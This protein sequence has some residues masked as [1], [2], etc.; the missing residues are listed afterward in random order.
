MLLNTELETVDMYMATGGAHSVISGRIAYV[1]GLTGPAI[2]VD[3]A[4]SSSLVAT[5]YAIKSLRTGECRMALAGGVNAIL[6][7]DVTI[8]LSKARMMATEGRCKAFAADAD[9]FVRSEGCG[10]LVLKRLAD[11][12]ADGDPILAV[13]R[14]TAIN[15]DGRSN[16]LTA[17]NGPSQVAVIRAA[18]ADAGLS[19]ADV[20]YVE[21]HGTG[22]TLG[23]P[24]E[25]Q[26]LG[27]AFA[28]GR[29]KD[30]PLMIGSIKTNMGHLE[31]AA[32]VAG[33][34]KLILSLQHAEIPPH[35]HLK[36]RSPHIPWEDLPLTIPTARTAWTGRRIGATSSFGFSGTNVHMIV[37]AYTPTPA[38]AP[39]TAQSRGLHLLTL[40]AKTKPALQSLVE[41][42]QHF[43]EHQ[44]D[45]AFS[46]IAYAANTSRAHLPQRLAL[47]AASAQQARQKLAE[48]QADPSA[49][50]VITSDQPAARPPDVAFLYTGHGAQ[51]AGMGRKLYDSEPV[52]RRVIDRCSEL[53]AAYLPKPLIEALYPGSDENATL[54]D[55]MT[56]GQP[57]IFA[58]QVA[59]AELWRDWGIQPAV[60]TGHSL[61][62]YAAAVAAG[63]FSLED[64]LKLVCARGRLMDNL[65]QSGS[66]ASVF[67]TEEEISAVIQPLAG[68]VSIAVIN[69]PTNIVISGTPS[70]V[71]QA[72]AAFEAKGI[73][74]RRLAIA[75]GAHSP[76]VDPMRDEF[77]RVAASVTFSAPRIDLV[78]CTTG[79]PVTAAEVSSVEYWWRHLRQ[80]VQFA[81]VMQTLQERGQAV[82]VEIGPHPVLLSI[83]QR[84]LPGGYGVWIPSLREKTD[85]TQ[86][87][88]EALGTL[89]TRGANIHWA[90]VY[91]GS[92]RS[93]LLL[94]T[95]P[96]DH[97]RYWFT[98][99]AKP[100]HS[101]AAAG[102]GLSPLLGAR[103]HSPALEDAVYQT[104]ISAVWPAY[105]DHHRIFGT[106]IAPSPAFIEMAARA[107]Q[108]LFGSG[109]YRVSNLAI[110]EAMILPEEGLR[111]A[112]IILTPNGENSA[113]FKIVSLEPGG[114][115][116]THTTGEVARQDAPAPD[117][118]PANLRLIADAQARC[119]E[120]MRGDVYYDNV[121]ALGLEFGESFRG[122]QHVWRRDGEALGK[123][124]LPE[125]LA[126]DMKNY[127][128]HPA[129]LDACFHLLGAPLPGAKVD[130][131][132]LL[133]GIEHFRMYRP[134]SGTLWNHT[135]L[136]DH[137]GETFSGDIRLYDESG[138]LVAE[139]Q[140]L[141][142]KRANRDLLMRAVRPRFD[143]WL[144]AVDW[145]PRPLP[146]EQTGSPRKASGWALIPDAGGFAQTLAAQLAANGETCRILVPGE[147]PPVGADVLY[148][149]GLDAGLEE[150][151]T[152]LLEKQVALSSGV[153]A[154]VQKARSSR[155]WIIT[156]GAQP[157]AGSAVEPGAA[158]L[159]GLG[160]VI[161]LEQP[162][163]WGGLV[164][165]DP[166]QPLAE[167][168]ASLIAEIRAGDIE[169]Q[170]AYRAGQR[171][172]AR[173]V[174]AARPTTQA[175]A[176]APDAAYLVTGGLGG[177]GLVLARWMAQ[178]GARNIV[179]I[180]R[181]G[182]PSRAEWDALPAGSP[183]A[184]Q[185]QAIREIE[186]ANAA[187]IEAL[188]VDVN[189]LPALREL[190]SS[191]GASRPA[192]KGVFHAAA[193]LGNCMV[194]Q[195][196]ADDLRAMFAPKVQGTWNLHRLTQA[197]DLDFWVLFS[198][199]TALW[200]SSQ[201][202]HYA[203]ANT[204]LDAFAHYR[205]ARNLPA[206]SVNWGT[207]EV[208]RVASQSD[209]QRVAQFGL[210]QM[211]A[212]AALST[213][214]AL[215]PS[216]L[217]Q[218]TVA[219][220]DWTPL[221]AA[222]EVRRAR[223]LLEGLESKKVATKTPPARSI[224]LAEQLQ[225]VPA[226]ERRAFIVEQVRQHVARV[227][228]APDPSVLNITQGL[229]E[230]GL[231]S[232]MSV[233]LKGRLETSVG[234]PLP[235][236]LTFNYPTIAD[237]ARFLDESVLTTTVSEP[238]QP[239]PRPAENVTEA[240]EEE[241][242]DLSEDDL[243]ALLA[244][245][246]SKLK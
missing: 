156:R 222:Y 216:H 167:Q 229:F 204:F 85:D 154:L 99:A 185:A 218:I 72:L 227:I 181:H 206:L 164:D 27:A 50:A 209:Q 199:T 47:V 200:G 60:V 33:L 113:A 171:S 197:L 17:P 180:G 42:Y 61:G 198:S 136:V 46:E 51:F 9:G 168:A 52:F 150:Q 15:Q 103:I 91:G 8:T 12:E 112:Q 96:F 21:T 212:E 243:A 107:A 24:I 38:T 39:E 28:Q 125:I 66:M 73:K 166:A 75:A 219:A 54:M 23:D 127:R 16:G 62:E 210:E 25:A 120:Q 76:L 10:M 110:L 143:D 144:Y 195:L 223:P 191:F 205:R 208:M 111:T 234:K 90:G 155:V 4:C 237:L 147:T 220:V 32:G 246:L 165:L 169:D 172:V 95:Y 48:Y 108:D 20:T 71:D 211:P 93:K 224:S 138:A 109:P 142:L 83:G 44:P 235:S 188:A 13:I 65:P 225:S 217:A 77:V 78:S 37:E 114:Q 106:S 86:Q 89:F 92:P 5:H 130:V 122:L 175:Y 94:P 81:R 69:A 104:Q 236:T 192:L 117:D 126:A 129:L 173:L 63:I 244:S 228:S 31:S 213:L 233:E 140:G 221:K 98:S 116:K 226:E 40:S 174:R 59:L 241:L 123:V 74:T 14:G 193:A 177:I 232:L 1:L 49:G 151:V 36:E 152:D 160:R 19:P 131:A 182:L 7:P 194:S 18:M 56:Y 231:D 70:G 53:A 148:L 190:I 134:P 80:P 26:A 245:K 170:T 179:L 128:F 201:L 41:R 178:H 162:E 163:A 55:T 97:Q 137:S 183:A 145:Q 22:T 119:D 149:P 196:G 87:M 207:W 214:A 64:G 239:A 67:A 141:Q 153:L 157:V 187:S 184:L 202:A 242:D 45:E 118:P 189:H 238:V 11:A 79:H 146:L 159:W 230:M 35:L 215:I 124:Q 57:A 115:W 82:F 34:M 135:V 176:F 2:S 3:T 240:P 139:A 102:P 100:V 58:I 186:A 29:G 161:A 43:L 105:L 68:Q 158:A 133:I 203:A 121:A 30:N 88:L 6:N 132:Y 84:V 101:L